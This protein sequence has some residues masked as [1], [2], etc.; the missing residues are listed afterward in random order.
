LEF[1]RKED[2]VLARKIEELVAEA[3]SLEREIGNSRA[4]RSGSQTTLQ[5]P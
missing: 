3:K 5:A 2:G 4:V 1:L